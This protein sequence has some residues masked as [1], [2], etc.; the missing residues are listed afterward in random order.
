L[1]ALTSCL[2]GEAAAIAAAARRINST[3]VEAALELLAGCRQRRSKLVVTGVGKS[4]IVARK[5]AATFSSIGLMALYLNPLDA[6]HGDLGVV[7]PDDVC[8]LLSNSGETLELQDALGQTIERFTYQDDWHAQTDGKG[9][10][11]TRLDGGKD[12]FEDPGTPDAWIAAWPNPG[13]E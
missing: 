5:I 13:S 2:E 6:L 7:A 10:C 11:L 3:Q 4:G 8:L 9:L 12:E 1:S